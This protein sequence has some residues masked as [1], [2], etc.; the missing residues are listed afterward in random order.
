MLTA[1]KKIEQQLTVLLR[2]SVRIHMMTQHGDFGLER[3]AYAILSKLADEGPQRL[4]VL[5]AGFGLDSST[6]TR[7]VHALERAGLAG[8]ERDPS[9]GRVFM[10]RLTADGRSVLRQTRRHRRARL[11]QALV[12]WPEVDVEEF[13]RLLE[14]F[15]AS[16]QRLEEKN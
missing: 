9:D 13:G 3:S 15:N 2:R 12:D 8:R 7:Q 1:H 16:L 11:Q 5:A 10:L 4:G 14:D 6:I